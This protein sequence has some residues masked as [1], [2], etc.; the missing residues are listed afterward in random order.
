[1]EWTPAKVEDVNKLVKQDL[2]N[3]DPEQASTF[4]RFRIAPHLAPIARLGRIEQVVV[5]AQKDEQVI[6]W[7]DVEEGFGVSAVDTDGRILDQD[8]N[9]NDLGLALNAWIEGRGA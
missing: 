8:C 9:Q 4:D 2:L 6:Y 1:M 5:V 3:C 7:E